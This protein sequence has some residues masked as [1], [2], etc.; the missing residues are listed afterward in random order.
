MK[1][2][3]VAVS[4]ILLIQVLMYANKPGD[5]TSLEAGDISFNMRFAPGGVEFL[6]GTSDT[7]DFTNEKSFWIAETPVTWE[8]WNTVREW[9]VDNGYV[10]PDTGLMGSAED[11]TDMNKN[12]PVTMVSW[13]SAVV[14]LNALTEWYNSNSGS[15]YDFVYYA[16]AS[17]SIPV[18]DVSLVTDESLA[19]KDSAKGF[20]LPYSMEWEFA[21]KYK[22]SDRSHGAIEY[23][24]KSGIY[25]TPGDYA[26][27]ARGDV[28]NEAALSRVA[29]YSENS[30][31]R[32]HTVGTAGKP[33]GDPLSG[34][35]NTLGLYDMSGNVNEWCF[36]LRGDSR[37][38][39]GG[40]WQDFAVYL[41]VGNA[42]SLES[43]KGYNF[44][45]FRI[46]RSD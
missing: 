30:N 32:T 20:R 41:Q 28:D 22:G 38:V 33:G 25:W 26:S 8:L 29:W 11:G 31:S 10:I 40:S 42:M 43:D 17:Y 44:V 19:V 14:W 34:N 24:E 7:G 45:G 18:K 39:R 13:K 35:A 27:G 46:V 6:T 3:S 1:K 15:N 37:V 23:P 21:A 9:A 36:D 12:H 16:E 4:L 5:K 2:F